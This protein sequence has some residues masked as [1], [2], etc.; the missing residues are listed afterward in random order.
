MSRS[1]VLSVFKTKP[2]CGIAGLFG[3]QQ[4]A[5][6]KIA[7][8]RLQHRGPDG[9]GHWSDEI[10]ELSHR[11]LAIL[12][13]SSS[14]QQPMTS[15]CGRYVIVF[16]GEIYNFQD[17]RQKMIGQGVIFRSHCDTEVILELFARVGS[18]CLERLRGMFAFAIWDTQNQQA[19]L[20]RDPLGIKPLYLLQLP[21]GG[22]AFASELRTLLALQGFNTHINSSALYAYLNT[23][24]V[25]E[26]ET[27]IQG[28]H[29]LPAGHTATW[30]QHH[31]QT[32]PYWKTTYHSDPAIDLETAISLTRQAL[33]ETVQ[34]HL[35]SDVPIGLFL[36]G[37]LDSSSILALSQQSLKTFTIGFAEA[38][39]DESE[40][41]AAIA[42]HFGADHH[43]LQLS[44]TQ[45]RNWLPDFLSAI[46]Q[47]TID[48]LNT[49]CISRL[50]HE[51]GLKVVLSGQGGDELF[52]GYPTF[53]QV[54]KMQR[55]RS[56]LGP[57]AP[58]LGQVL[59]QYRSA[60]SQRLASWLRT[61][62][63][64]NSAYH[65][66]RCIFSPQEAKTLLA[67]W[68]LALN[69]LEIVPKHHPTQLPNSQSDQIAWL[70]TNNYLR[71]Q[72]LRDSDVFSM[73]WS[74]E[75][76]VPFVD[77]TLFEV[78]AP[79]PANIRLATGKQLLSNAV[80]D[81]P[82]WLLNQPKQGFRFP[83]QEW[84]DTDYNNDLNL[85][86]TPDHLDLRPW[87]RRWSLFIL[88]DWLQRHLN[89]SL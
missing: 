65:C 9:Q 63:T 57:F 83:F 14:G 35:V 16:N 51:Q 86:T 37:G 20:A 46:D 1:L 71:N 47:P 34:S 40:R 42:A 28:I 23:G 68:G 59:Q 77:Q 33:Q 85:P 79:I 67:H 30:Y 27:L 15:A 87:Y 89:L 22:L 49:F 4:L 3:Q 53:E 61:P 25:P 24:S 5:F 80:S 21:G 52:G 31:L 54:P 82:D 12:D 73:A 58:L 69:S 48:G 81:L 55:W 6:S 78:I 76:R 32:T 74:L 38:N 39:Y 64:L 26:P 13:L 8:L 36:S 50:A 18:L 2:M 60:L 66:Y 88:Q 41:A 19:F 70:E 75:L 45:V 10:A 43:P 11:R 84:L 56:C 72:L 62:P 17:L 44:M 7:D 29:L